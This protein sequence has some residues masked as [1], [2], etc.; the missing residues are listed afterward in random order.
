MFVKGKVSETNTLKTP[1]TE[2]KCGSF[3]SLSPGIRFHPHNPFVG[4]HKS[5]NR[6]EKKVYENFLAQNFT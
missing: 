5:Q 6:I 2:S 3:L 4:F 1:K